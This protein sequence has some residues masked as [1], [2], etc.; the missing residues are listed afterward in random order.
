MKN[1]VDCGRWRVHYTVQGDGPPLILLHGGAPASSGS[2]SFSRNID[3]FAKSF[4]TYAIDFPGWGK[5]SHRLIPVG[6][7][8][9]PMEVAGEVVV[10][11]MQAVGVARAHLLGG[12]FGGAAALYTALNHPSLV[13]RLVLAAPGGGDIGGQLTPGLV[14]LLT[15]YSGEGPTLEKLRTL[16][17][18]MVF[19]PSSIPD[20]MIEERFAL[21]IT[22]EALEGFP[23][24]LPPG[25]LSE[26]LPLL[27]AHPGLPS[28]KAPVL[29]VW[30][31]NDVVQP[32]DALA[33]FHRLPNQRARVFEAC[34]HWPYWEHAEAFNEAVFQF[35]STGSPREGTNK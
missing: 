12:S 7:W 22:A 16:M 35:L 23:L 8:A 20:A 9:N 30:G 11:F 3:S 17:G 18:H 2:S 34:G 4:R 19:D 6:Q 33:S 5:S 32:L 24:R 10:T 27:C 31:R 15:Y 14:S 1:E 21:S 29:F 13:D 25:G 28:M 26:P